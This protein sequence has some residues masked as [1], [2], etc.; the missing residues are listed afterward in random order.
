[1]KNTSIKKIASLTFLLSFAVVNAGEHDYMR[2]EL[3]EVTHFP[4]MKA[5][6]INNI[7]EDIENY[8]KWPQMIVRQQSDSDRTPK[9]SDLFPAKVGKMFQNPTQLPLG[10]DTSEEDSDDSLSSYSFNSESE[11]IPEI[12]KSPQPSDGGGD[13][14]EFSSS[15]EFGN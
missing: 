3:R 5:V 9:Q 14:L 11:S 1:M 12:I 8:K 10:G 7:V 4:M 15:S 6:K 2:G 13:A